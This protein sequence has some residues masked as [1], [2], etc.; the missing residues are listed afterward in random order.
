MRRAL[1]AAAVT[2]ALILSAGNVGYAAPVIP[3]PPVEGLPVEAAPPVTA[4]VWILYDAT[5]GVVLGSLDADVERPM[6]ST[7]KIMTALVALRHGDL[8]SLVTVSRR[9]AD[10]GEAEIGLLPGEQFPLRLLIKTAVVRSANDAAVAVAEAVG[11]SEAAFVELMNAEASGMGLTHTRFA[12]PHGLDAPEHWS[13]ARDLL[14]M[15]L[16]AMEYPD[17]SEAVRTSQLGFPPAPD[18]TERIAKT[19]NRLLADY[20]G[21]IGVKTGFTTRAGLV[22]VA[23]AEREGR[24]IYAVVMGSE[25]ESAHF[26]DATALLDYAY[27]SFGVVPLVVAGQ[28]YALRRSG[29][30]TDALSATATVEAF[31]HLASAGLLLPELALDDGSPSVAV[32]DDLPAVELAQPERRPLPGLGDAFAWIGRLWQNFVDTG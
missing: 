13:S 18:G 30:V 20:E 3:V 15:T 8:E 28:P 32:T 17:F 27:A 19:T 16:A 7:T 21:A 24:R 6:A 5:H 9:A 26:E 25:G 11:G 14:T 1:L 12:N 29:P 4:K 2:A 23:A 10:A 31:I 22:L